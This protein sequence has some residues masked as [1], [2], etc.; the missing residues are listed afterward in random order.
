MSL[1]VQHL[2][3]ALA[4]AN[5]LLVLAAGGAVFYTGRILIKLRSVEVPDTF[6]PPPVSLIAAA[7]DEERNIEE[8]VRSWLRIDY[9]DLEITI[10]DDRSTDQTGPILDRLAT[11]DARLNVVH[12]T[13]LPS[14]WLGKNHALECG[15]EHSQG[16]WLLFTDADVVLAPDALR[17][18]VCLAE[19]Q[20]IDH[21]AAT[22]DVT[23][24]SWWLQAF[25][26]VFAIF[27]TLFIRPWQVRNLRSGAHVGIGAFNL[28]R[29][30]VYRAVGG[31]ARIAMRPDDDVKFGKI[32]K[33]GGYRQEMVLG[34]GMIAV[35]WYAS[36]SELIRGLEK[37]AFSAIDYR[38]WFVLASV[39]ALSVFHVWPFVAVCIVS[40]A[41]RWIYLAVVTMLLAM[42][43]RSAV[44]N[45]L[46]LSCV[47]AYPAVVLLFCYIQLRTMCLNLR[48]GGLS[49]R[50]TFYSLDELRANRV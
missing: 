21:I 42:N 18:A 11:E 1:S 31:Y 13:D 50:G 3:T 8:A 49:W 29:A 24:N 34:N 7:R 32:I 23:V 19:Q 35:E 27:F 28:V 22:P 15:A 39:A 41:A 48:D 20:Q 14:G 10:V 33:Q 12:L 36:V 16:T 9:P 43:L 4:V 45:G 40:G 47:P 25:C 17:R 30:D 46:P 37:N 26:S 2:L 44:A 5:L 38:I 6:V